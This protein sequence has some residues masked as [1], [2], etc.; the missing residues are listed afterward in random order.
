MAKAGIPDT[1]TVAELRALPADKVAAINGSYGP[2]VDGKLMIETDSQA[3]ARGHIPDVPLIIGSNSGEDSLMGP[4][5][6]GEAA[7]T[8]IPAAVKP[9]YATEAAASPDTF[10]RAV[11]TDRVMGGPARWVAA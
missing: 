3:I 11:F 7:L 8:R 5:T 2:F 10:A 6:L 9:A 4:M 1:A